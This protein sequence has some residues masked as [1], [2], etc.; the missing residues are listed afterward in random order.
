LGNSPSRYQKSG[1]L[2]ADIE[3]VKKNTWHSC[4]ILIAFIGQAVQRRPLGAVLANMYLA[5]LKGTGRSK[6][7]EIVICRRLS[8]VL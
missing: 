3:N 2:K 4:R 8:L 7:C 6:Y 1:Y 5:L